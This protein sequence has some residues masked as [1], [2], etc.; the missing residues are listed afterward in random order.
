MEEKE[1]LDVRLPKFRV[2]Q[3]FTALSQSV[4]W[5]LEQMKISQIWPKTKGAGIKIAVLDTGCP[6][7]LSQAGVAT[8]HPDLR[9]NVI[10]GE[11]LSFVPNEDIYDYQ[12]HSTAVCGVIAA[13]DNQLGFVGYAPEAKIIT[14]KVLDKN[15]A[16]SLRWIENALKKCI[17]TKPD[18]VS[19]SLGSIM[20][21][22]LMHTLVKKLDSM[23]I[24]VI[25][26]AGNGADFEG[27]NYPAKYD[28]AFAIGAYDKELNIADFSAIGDELDFAFPGVDI[29]TTWLDFGYT[30][31]SGTSFACP[32]CT[33]L[34]A[35]IMAE[36]K[37]A[38]M[39]F[40][41]CQNTIWLYN[42]LKNLATNPK[43]LAD[44]TSDWGWGYID[45]QKL[46][47][48]T[49]K[50]EDPKPISVMADT[51]KNNLLNSEI[52]GKFSDNEIRQAYP[53][54][55]SSKQPKKIYDIVNNLPNVF[56]PALLIHRLQ[57]KKGGTQ[58][59]FLKA[60]KDLKS[61]LVTITKKNYSIWN[62][63]YWIYKHQ[64]GK[65]KSAFDSNGQNLWK[66]I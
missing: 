52:M 56:L 45:V 4:D 18:I 26:A 25:C 37:A 53:E 29:E 21:T 1:T 2:E 64:A 39:N 27:V 32:A 57:Y 44:Q 16:G 9:H 20:D 49:E 36:K 31:I 51:H 11:C 58:D 34:V 22:P 8:I 7:K 62:P 35:L 5:G 23:G 47:D 13:E 17:E 48:D 43:K 50:F 66:Y 63:F 54:I 41:E 24:P 12:G 60:N 42:E 38:G 30:K 10:L 6:A 14:Y 40:S 65:L 59:D 3:L 61:N 15:G 19:M 33:G 55:F 28:E 46:I